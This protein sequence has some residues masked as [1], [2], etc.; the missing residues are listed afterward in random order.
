[1]GLGEPKFVEDVRSTFSE[2]VLK[3]DIC[4][5]TQEHFS[6][7]DVPGIFKKTTEGITTKA[8]IA[9]VRGM[10]SSYMENPRSVIL[11]VIPANVDIAT[12]EILELAVEFDAEGVRTLG[13]LTKPDLV[14]QGAELHVVELIQGKRHALNLGWCIVK[15]LGQKELLTPGVD[16]NALEKAYFRSAA[17]WNG[18]DKDRLGVEALKVRLQ[19]ILADTIRRTFPKV[20]FWPISPSSIIAAIDVSDPR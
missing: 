6:V 1:M 12:Q 17:P 8:D 10:V 5:P 4:G 13:V 19:E 2:D 16:R 9:M 11:A 20:W 7:V 14:D 18:L 3:L 15:N